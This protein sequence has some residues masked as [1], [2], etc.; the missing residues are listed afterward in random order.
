MTDQEGPARRAFR[1]A[2]MGAGVTGSYLGYL[3]Q[4]AFLNKD[5]KA[6]RLKH[7]HTKAAKRVTD[8]MLAMK[9]PAMKLGQALSLHHDILPEETLAELATLQMRA[10]GMHASLVNAQFRASMGRDPDD[11]YAKFEPKP[12]AAA[13]LGQVHRATLKD[14]KAVAVKIQYPGIRDAIKND[15]TWFR[16]VSKPAQLSRYIP[17]ETLAEL[18][19]QIVAECDYVREA[20]NV[21][22][23]KKGLSSLPWVELPTVHRALST[24]RVLTMS[25]VPG[26]HLDDFL[27]TRPS[28]ALRDRVGERLFELFY[29]Q[30]LRLEA[31]HADPHWG[32]YLFRADGSIGVVDFG[33]VKYFPAPFVANMR[34]VFLYNG[35]QASEHFRELLEERYAQSGTKLSRSALKAL[36]EISKGFYGRVYPPDPATDGK[37][38]DFSHGAIVKDYLRETTKVGLA[39]ATLPEYVFWGRA[40]SGLYQT[41]HRLRARVHTSAIVRKYL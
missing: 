4:S 41:L 33:C 31:L 9:G 21:A 37:P 15:F 40:E 32:N 2:A 3:A 13:S 24:D 27:A 11:V 5:E 22:F 38:F 34:R 18:E 20:E 6:K 25:M 16:N 28:Q 17:A 35:S 36:A 7:T 10:P 30:L 23:F 39:K 26:M 1:V 29:V 12:F 8:G 19:E 14:G